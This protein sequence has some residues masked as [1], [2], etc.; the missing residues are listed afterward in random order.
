MK[1]KITI[2][3]DESILK[4][5]DHLANIQEAKNRSAIIEDALKEKYGEFSDVTVIIFGHDRKW[6]NRA[7]PFD[8]PKPLLE[9]RKRSII[10]R[11][12]EAFVTAG[13]KN[14]ICMIE[15]NSTKMFEDEL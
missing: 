15:P 12:I 1:K 6:D 8:T 9:I 10:D 7:Y 4:K 11:Q 5:I 2:S 3:L 13:I 14:I